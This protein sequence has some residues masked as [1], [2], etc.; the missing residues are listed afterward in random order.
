MHST[1]FPRLILAFSIAAASLIG[2]VQSSLTGTV[3]DHTGAVIP[4]ATVVAR[5]T[6]TDVTYSA[7]TQGAGT[8]LYPLLPPGY[9]NL[10][11]VAPGFKK[12]AS[13]GLM[14]D[15]GSTRAIDIPMEIGNLT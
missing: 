14:L 3:K 15:T 2:Q 5:N 4:G 11:R 12:S 8:F 7:A 9:Y 10:T 1:Q 13:Q 6:A